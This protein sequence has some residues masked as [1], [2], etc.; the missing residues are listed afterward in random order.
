MEQYGKRFVK[1]KP[2]LRG[3]MKLHVARLVEEKVLDAEDLADMI[4]FMDE[5]GLDPDSDFANRRFMV[6]LQV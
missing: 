5:D 6:A 2:A 1:G 3:A 4:T